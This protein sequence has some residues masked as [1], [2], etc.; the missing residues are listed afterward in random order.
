MQFYSLDPI[1]LLKFYANE[2]HRLILFFPQRSG[3]P[4]NNGEHISLFFIHG[5][6]C[7]LEVVWTIEG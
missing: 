3:L 2:D 5:D 1:C 6:C 7:D 4:S